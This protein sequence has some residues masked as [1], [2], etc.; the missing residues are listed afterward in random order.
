MRFYQ[1]KNGIPAESESRPGLQKSIPVPIPGPKI[2]PGIGIPVPLP[3]PAFETPPM[4]WPKLQL[5]SSKEF[6]SKFLFAW[7]KFD[8]QI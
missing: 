8:S 5:C 2:D 6:G 3:N 4:Q 1:K 7:Q